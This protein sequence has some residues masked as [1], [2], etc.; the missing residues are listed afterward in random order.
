MSTA[1]DWGQ[2]QL[3]TLK[4]VFDSIASGVKL[5]FLLIMNFFI[6]SEKT[7]EF[8]PGLETVAA[9]LWQTLLV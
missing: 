8:L 2:R 6:E 4:Q 7:T 9:S 5:L 1:R 3:P